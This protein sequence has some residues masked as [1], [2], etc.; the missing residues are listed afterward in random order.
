MRRLVFTSLAAAGLTAT[1]ALAQAAPAA[2]GGDA[3]A[4]RLGAPTARM[5][6][7][8]AALNGKFANEV[9]QTRKER[10][11]ETDAAAIQKRLLNQAR[12]LP[13]LCM[14]SHC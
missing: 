12:L 7:D 4:T 9:E 2:Q 3:P 1:P 5:P 6:V 11:T 13:V 10:S 8:L 14:R